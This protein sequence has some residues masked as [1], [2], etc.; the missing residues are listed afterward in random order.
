MKTKLIL[1]PLLI[2]SIIFFIF[3]YL[4]MTERDPAK[5]PSA[6]I[7]K[8]VPIFTA[9]SV[10]DKKIFVSQ[11]EFNGKTTIVNFFFLPYT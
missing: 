5:I 1:Y 4:L 8:K 9:E 10:I 7:N 3:L 11:N 6:L 2:F